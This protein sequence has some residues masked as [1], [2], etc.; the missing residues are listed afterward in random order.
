L[1]E[2]G[3]LPAMRHRESR[4]TGP[5]LQG[6][7]R[8]WAW[9]GQ[10]N[11]HHGEVERDRRRQAQQKQRQDTG[12]APEVLAVRQSFRTE[13]AE[14]SR[15]WDGRTTRV[16]GRNLELRPSSSI[17]GPMWSTKVS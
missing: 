17:Q 12:N 9:S 11:W 1:K 3:H 4:A 6:L 10:G 13:H 15:E 8:H 16:D 5:A 7:S 2:E 14:G